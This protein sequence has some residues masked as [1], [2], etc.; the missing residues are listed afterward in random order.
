[1]L[2]AD[3]N[4]DHSAAMLAALGEAC[5]ILH[6]S[7]D[8]CLVIRR[9][10]PHPNLPVSN[11][12]KYHRKVEDAL[13]QQGVSLAHESSLHYKNNAEG[14]A[15]DRRTL[16]SRFLVVVA[17]CYAEESPWVAT[18]LARGNPGETSLVRVRDMRPGASKR[19]RGPG[20]N[21]RLQPNERAIQMG[22]SAMMTLLLT[23]VPGFDEAKATCVVQIQ[24]GDV[25]EMAHTVLTVQIAA[26]GRGAPSST[27]H[28]LTYRGLYIGLGGRLPESD[29]TLAPYEAD[30]KNVVKR[31][32]LPVRHV[33]QARLMDKWWDTHPEA[34]SREGLL[35]PM[36]DSVPLPALRLC[37]WVRDVPV[38][39]EVARQRFAVG[40][41]QA[42][43]WLQIEKNFQDVFGR[44]AEESSASPVSA[45]Q[46]T[47]HEGPDFAGGGGR[48]PVDTQALWE[49]AEC[50]E[51]TDP[52]AVSQSKDGV[53]RL[54]LTDTQGVVATLAEHVDQTTDVDACELLGFGLGAYETVEANSPDGLSSLA[55]RVPDDA[56]FVAR[57]PEDAVAPKQLASLAAICHT[58]ARH[59]G[60]PDTALQ[61]HTMTP[62]GDFF[63]RYDMGL[64]DSEEVYVFKPTEQEE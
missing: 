13:L 12:I 39:P 45:R 56:T 38:V 14:H 3:L 35:S 20:D 2:Y 9:A 51:P 44:P 33:L 50:E 5:K 53:L 21:T 31:A 52:N 7:P 8:D 6:N 34:G 41:E 19:H 57:V 30:G 29:A 23:A 18:T 27:A 54:F 47:A 49:P 64:Q 25:A 60:I 24:P 37:T 61:N 48:Q 58:A 17:G 40:S 32:C 43:Q 4:V 62:R 1:M 42:E 26:T 63:H 28:V 16:E 22:D 11:I 15:R 59:D 55:C 46:S 36:G 10:L